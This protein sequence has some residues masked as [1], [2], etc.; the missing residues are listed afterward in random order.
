MPPKRQPQ[1]RAV[2]SEDENEVINISSDDDTYAHLDELATLK[3]EIA[4]LKRKLAQSEAAHTSKPVLGDIANTERVEL[5]RSERAQLKRSI[6]I[7]NKQVDKISKTF[8]LQRLN[9]KIEVQNLNTY[10]TELEEKRR[11]LAA[12]NAEL[13]V[14]AKSVD[15]E[16]QALQVEKEKLKDEEKEVLSRAAARKLILKD[17]VQALQTLLSCD[18]C[19]ANSDKTYCSKQCGH[20]ACVDCYRAWF[21]VNENNRQDPSCPKCRVIIKNELVVNFALRDMTA[22]ITEQLKEMGFEER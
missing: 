17:A 14:M 11:Q 6:T 12:D 22:G 2:K 18:I 9:H 21:K 20:S 16:R 13:V 5:S 15:L 4:A 10:I 19:Y 1:K 3:N 7:S 8:E